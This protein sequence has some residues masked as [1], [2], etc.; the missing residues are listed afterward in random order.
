M[1]VQDANVK[2]SKPL[3]GVVT[4]DK[5]DKAGVCTVERMVR[6]TRYGKYVKRR[7]KIM[8]HDEK[9]QCKVGDSVL[10]IPSRP[11]SARKRFDLLKVVETAKA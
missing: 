8:F 11:H 6:H 5:M 4:S 1:S 2:K 7:T 9:N 3:Q 10:I